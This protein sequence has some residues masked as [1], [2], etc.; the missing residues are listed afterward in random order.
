MKW[1]TLAAATLAIAPLAFQTTA[2]A[3]HQDIT[4]RG[5][6]IPAEK[7]GTF[8]M[9]QVS[10]VGT[11]TMPDWAHGRRV[12]YWLKDIKKM[13][14]HANHMVEV[15]GHVSDFKNSE[16]ELKAGHQP[17]GELYVEFEGPGR[18]VRVPASASSGVAS[19]V[20]TTGSS[21]KDLKTML[22]IVDVKKITRLN[23]AC[24]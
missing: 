17:S 13:Q 1:A 15:N 20:G 10:E 9:T 4:L 6:V 19:S 3:A 16:V 2:S 11:H 22:A 18:D 24:Q 5:C 21:D 7:K 12:V 8:V 14:D 23:E